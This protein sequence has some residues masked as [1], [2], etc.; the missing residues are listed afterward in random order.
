[1][2]GTVVQV[3][4]G[5]YYTIAGI[6]VFSKLDGQ[7]DIVKPTSTGR[8]GKSKDAPFGFLAFQAGLHEPQIIPDSGLFA[9]EQGA[10]TVKIP[11]EIH[12]RRN[13]P[14]ENLYNPEDPYWPEWAEAK[15]AK[16]WGG[17]Q[18]LLETNRI[19]FSQV[20]ARLKTLIKLPLPREVKF[21][22]IGDWTDGGTFTPAHV[23]QMSITFVGQDDFVESSL[24][25]MRNLNKG[26][27]ATVQLSVDG[28]PVTK[29]FPAEKL[30]YPVY[31]DR[32]YNAKFG[33]TQDWLLGYSHR[34]HLRPV[35]TSMYQF[36]RWFDYEN[37]ETVQL[38]ID[39]ATQPISQA[40]NLDWW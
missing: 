17:N 21:D 40:L 37:P 13:L 15:A 4:A 30:T 10:W 24:N 32:V 22:L 35:G 19:T 6:Y 27:S 36:Q 12:L 29:D 2:L 38:E 8:P 20:L 7:Q 26:Q 33:V 9:Y 11:W 23:T 25:E 16:R 14:P 5:L 3:A 18:P 28:N 39:E 31:F 34:N 1:M